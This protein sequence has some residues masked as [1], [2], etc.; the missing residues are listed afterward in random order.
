MA[1]GNH[2]QAAVFVTV[3]Q[4]T[5]PGEPGGVPHPMFGRDAPWRWWLRRPRRAIG[6]R[7]F[8]YATRLLI[9]GV[10][11][12]TLLV[13]FQTI[14][15]S[16]A[17]SLAAS[18]DA[19]GLLA[20]ILRHLRELWAAL[21]ILWAALTALSL[22]LVDL[23]LLGNDIARH[24]IGPTWPGLSR[25]IRVTAIMVAV[26]ALLLLK[27]T[28]PP[29]LMW[30]A[31]LSVLVT[32]SRA[33]RLPDLQGSFWAIA[34]AA[35]TLAAGL[36]AGWYLGSLLVGVACLAYRLRHSALVS[37]I[38]VL[39]VILLLADWRSMAQ[40][41]VADVANGL[42]LL[43]LGLLVIKPPHASDRL[44][45]VTAMICLPLGAALALI[46]RLLSPHNRQTRFGPDY[47]LDH[48]WLAA[49]VIVAALVAAIIQHKAAWRD[50]LLCIGTILLVSLPMVFGFSVSEDWKVAGLFL[51]LLALRSGQ[52]LRE[53][54]SFPLPTVLSIASL[55]YGLAYAYLLGVVKYW[56]L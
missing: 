15:E 6:K 32:A 18:P 22:F 47:F 34:I 51:F 33:E 50:A 46:P 29:G 52:I 31:A 7:T 25:T 27:F 12:S 55:I 23:A 1:L 10:V 30:I 17:D 41:N 13:T 38:T 26:L 19:S 35:A 43:G 40:W 45:R 11:G 14:P 28:A 37:L 48:Q 20:S 53:G 5:G 4:S 39:G 44:L 24:W 54:R 56:G 2:S 3:E 9:L 49:L 8:A 36:T 21:P 42:A 16:A